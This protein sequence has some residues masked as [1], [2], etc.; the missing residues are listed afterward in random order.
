MF[1]GK[2]TVT[3]LFIALFPSKAFVWSLY[4]SAAASALVG[5]V[6]RP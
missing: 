1:A 4:C 3:F 5:L 6:N 2:V